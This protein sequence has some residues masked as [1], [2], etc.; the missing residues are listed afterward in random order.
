MTTFCLPPTKLGLWVDLVGLVTRST[1]ARFC[2][3]GDQVSQ[4]KARARSLT[5]DI[6]SMAVGTWMPGVPSEFNFNAGME[7][8][9]SLFKAKK[10]YKIV[11]VIQPPF[12]QWNET[13]REYL[14]I[15]K[16]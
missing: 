9:I 6:F 12:M 10:V 4:V 1:K 11:S 14:D 5:I 16:Y 13:T 15:M 8:Q 3:L 7:D 2:Q